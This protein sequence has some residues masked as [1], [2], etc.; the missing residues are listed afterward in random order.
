MVQFLYF[1]IED[2]SVILMINKQ[3]SRV[4]YK[5]IDTSFISLLLSVYLYK[6]IKIHF[7]VYMNES[8]LEMQQSVD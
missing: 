8:N 1:V 3:L 4:C 7:I 6:L 5:L 2:D